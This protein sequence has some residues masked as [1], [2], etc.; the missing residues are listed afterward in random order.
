M[1]HGQQRRLYCTTCG[2]IGEPDTAVSGS[3]GVELTLWGLGLMTC[4]MCIPA[5]MYSSWRRKSARQVCSA[6][7]AQNL[8]PT[9]S[10]LATHKLPED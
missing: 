5:L 3:L 10:P 8:I 6:C 1:I 7:G 9:D 4:V 2:S